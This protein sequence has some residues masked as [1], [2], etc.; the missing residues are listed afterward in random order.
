MSFSGSLLSG[1]SLSGGQYYGAGLTVTGEW[2]PYQLFA[3]GEVGAWYDP[4][5][6]TTLF[7]D[8][9]GTTPVTAAGQVVG[10]ML[11][12]SRGLVL[13]PE[14]VTNGGP[15]FVNTTGWSAFAGGSVA[16]SGGA[17]VVT[18]AGADTTGAYFGFP[19]VAGKTYYYDVTYSLGTTAVI[20]MFVSAANAGGGSALDYAGVSSYDFV[21]APGRTK[22]FF[23]ATDD[24]STFNFFPRGV[25]L[26]ASITSITIRELDGRH[27]VQG[28]ATSVR[29]IY[30]VEPAT[31][32]RNLLTFTEQ[33]DNAAWSKV[34]SAI[35]ANTEVA[36]DG[37]TTA[38]T[39]TA[40]ASNA[41]HYLAALSNTSSGSVTVSIYAK[42]GTLSFLQIAGSSGGF[43]ANFN[44]SNG[45]LGTA[46]QS[47]FLSSAIED[48]G[49]GWYRCSVTYTNSSDTVFFMMVSSASAAFF[50][51]WTTAGTETLHLWGAQLETGSTAT[52]YQRVVSQYDVTESGV[53]S[54]HYLAFDGIDD[55]LQTGTITPGTDKVQV[56]AGVRKLSDAAQALVVGLG[57]IT[58]SGAFELFAPSAATGNDFNF[59]ANGGTTFVQAAAGSRPSP[60]SVVAAGII[61]FTL[62]S[63]EV[64]NRING[65]VAVTS[66][67]NAGTANFRTDV[68]HIGRRGGSSL[69]FNGNLYGLIV[70]FGA[71]LSASQISNAERWMNGKTGAY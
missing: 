39:L 24:F 64:T 69:P 5:D 59:A 50:E 61:D 22:R 70:R 37:F 11:D 7:Q 47:R 44:I 18:G 32:R 52:A 71:N 65:A 20:D 21:T 42:A 3:A 48:A 36:P 1:T 16:V 23:A 66:S 28:G 38:E 12:K 68:I 31:G 33:F 26:T 10:L 45:T 27:A 35:S 60:I 56:F 46:G 53:A 41:R 17:L 6:I 57:N 8:A 29:P 9:A 67:G 49:G 25:G 15:G 55:W 51:T 54:R 30:A 40:L 62:A 19:T 13:G 2:T 4:S 58:Q 43:A 34:N 63:G 14:L